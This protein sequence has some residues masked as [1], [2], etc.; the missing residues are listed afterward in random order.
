MKSQ[1]NIN[2]YHSFPKVPL[3]VIHM[4]HDLYKESFNNKALD[5]IMVV[6]CII[7]TVM[8]SACYLNYYDEIIGI[9]MF[10]Y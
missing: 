9:N 7:I 8:I 4:V 5:I 10:N 2:R 1:D 3:I 6:K